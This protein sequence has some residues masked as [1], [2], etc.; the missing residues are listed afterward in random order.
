MSIIHTLRASTFE[1]VLAFSMPDVGRITK[2]TEQMKTKILK[3]CT[4]WGMLGAIVCAFVNY[5]L[6]FAV[7]CVT[8][9]CAVAWLIVQDNER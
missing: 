6:T 7:L 1:R 4:L 9:I 8:A 3:N 5:W 2:T